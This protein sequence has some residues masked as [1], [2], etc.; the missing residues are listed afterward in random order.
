MNVEIVVLLVLLIIFQATLL[1]RD[2]KTSGKKSAIKYYEEKLSDINESKASEA[3]YGFSFLVVFAL[4]ATIIYYAFQ[5]II[6]FIK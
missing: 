6:S 1:L 4:R 5:V 3:A 2:V